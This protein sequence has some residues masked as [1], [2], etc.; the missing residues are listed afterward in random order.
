MAGGRGS[1][2]DPVL[3]D[4]F[5]ELAPDLARRLPRDEATLTT[6]LMN[7]LLPYLERLVPVQ[8]MSEGR[9]QGAQ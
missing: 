7:R 1:H 5:K 6:Q 2:F 4:R 8:T 3:F 9:E